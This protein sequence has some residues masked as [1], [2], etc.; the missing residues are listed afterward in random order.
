[1]NKM[2]NKLKSESGVSVLFALLLFLVVSMVSVTILSAATSSVKRTHAVKLN[3]QDTLALD[4][5]SLL[6]EK[7]ITGC[8]YTV[9]KKDGT[10][11]NESITGDSPFEEEL[12]N[13]S[14]SIVNNNFMTND[15]DLFS[16]EATNMDTVKVTYCVSYKDGSYVVSFGLTTDE[17]SNISYVNYTLDYST[18]GNK[19]EN[20]TIKWN[21]YKASAKKG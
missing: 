12:L 14:R 3:T 10:L 2:K 9:T 5:A 4:S 16:V 19:N 13:I 11:L 20:I 17:D 1:M 15:T 7:G 18:S 8:E 6:L 21:A